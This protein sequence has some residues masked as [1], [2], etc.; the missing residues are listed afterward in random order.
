MICFVDHEMTWVTYLRCNLRCTYCMPEDGVDLT[1]NRDLLAKDEL[2][3]LVRIFAAEGVT[4]VRL[5]GGEPLIRKDVVEIVGGLKAVPGIETVAMT[6][7]GV[8]LLGKLPDLLEAGLDALNISLDTLKRRKFEFISRRPS[9][10]HP[11][12]ID[13]ILAV[14]KANMPICPKVSW[15]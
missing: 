9:A 1:P 7:N 10:V 15:C 6:T 12:V 13:S 11:R 5:T 8:S 2:L 14:E 3:E 4:K